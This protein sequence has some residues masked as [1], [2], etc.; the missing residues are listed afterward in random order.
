[1][2]LVMD[3]SLHPNSVTDVVTTPPS[4]QR[5]AEIRTALTLLGVVA[6]FQLAL[7]AGAPWGAAAWGGVA[8]GVLPGPLRVAS[9]GSMLIYC[10]LAALVATHRL[11]STAR[12]RLLTGASLFM[13]LGIIGNLATQ[14]PVERAW[15]P[16]AAALAVLFWR[17]RTDAQVS[18]VTICPADRARGPA[19]SRRGT[20]CR[21]RAPGTVGTG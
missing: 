17:L 2:G 14:S 15:A 19:P 8:T 9:A 21:S 6:A 12:R 20:P 10:G 3:M 7:A 13:V 4:R 11:S 5:T 18:S 16:V 1:M